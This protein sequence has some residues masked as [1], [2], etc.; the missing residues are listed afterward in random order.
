ME[1]TVVCFGARLVSIIIDG[2]MTSG[3]NVMGTLFQMQQNCSE[4][5]LNKFQSYQADST[6]EPNEHQCF[7]IAAILFQK[8]YALD[9][10]WDALDDDAQLWDRAVQE[11]I[12]EHP[13][14]FS[15]TK[16]DVGNT[17]VEFPMPAM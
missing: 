4:S 12:D 8:H 1:A 7:C 2:Q 10:S 13:Q 16:Q 9:S 5:M 14:P 15:I 11:T 6:G 17:S 3:L